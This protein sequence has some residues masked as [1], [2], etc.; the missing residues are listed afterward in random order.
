MNAQPN[1]INDHELTLLVKAAS[2]GISAKMV[3]M[4]DGYEFFFGIAG[5][6][7]Q[8]YSQRNGPRRFK[9]PARALRFLRNKGIDRVEIEGISTFS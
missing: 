1:T 9:C 6:Q 4:K 7:Y 5:E 2:A 8:L 3:G